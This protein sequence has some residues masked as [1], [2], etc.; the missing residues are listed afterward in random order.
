MHGSHT[1]ESPRY[2]QQGSPR[3]VN[4][5]SPRAYQQNTVAQEMPI[6][7]KKY[8]DGIVNENAELEKK[9][10]RAKEDPELKRDMLKELESAEARVAELEQ[11]VEEAYYEDKHRDV[12][13]GQ[14]EVTNRRIRELAD[15]LDQASDKNRDLDRQVEH[16]KKLEDD[17]SQVM[18]KMSEVMNQMITAKERSSALE[19]ELVTARNRDS[20]IYTAK[21]KMQ[22]MQ[23]QL[24][25]ANRKLARLEDSLRSSINKWRNEPGD[26]TRVVVNPG[27]SGSL[28]LAKTDRFGRAM[29]NG[30]KNTKISD[31]RSSN[32]HAREVDFRAAG[33]SEVGLRRTVLNLQREQSSKKLR[34]ELLIGQNDK[35]AKQVQILKAAMRKMGVSVEGVKS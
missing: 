34:K 23:I 2:R 10:E 16:K 7:P 18:Q 33:V 17:F 26:F 28:T 5:G 6:I 11:K 13:S 12:M 21:R 32:K 19:Q 27:T 1:Q 9:I 25:D 15:R 22:N 31:T 29:K 24:N 20:E 14:L 30:V 4:R 35:L 3:N 8:I